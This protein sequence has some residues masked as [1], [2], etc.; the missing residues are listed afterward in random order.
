[1]LHVPCRG[2]REVQRGYRCRCA[3]GVQADVQEDMQA[4]V[5]EDLQA[6][7]MQ[8]D[9]HVHV[10]LGDDVQEVQEVNL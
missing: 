1:M 6:D 5:R 9:M 2:T 8:A 3:D 7:I 4:D 10:H